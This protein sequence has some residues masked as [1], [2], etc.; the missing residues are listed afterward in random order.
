MTLRNATLTDGSTFQQSAEGNI[1][2]FVHGIPV[3][4]TMGVLLSNTVGGVIRVRSG[5]A[6]C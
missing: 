2:K 6:Q 5:H 4:I 1:V 3:P